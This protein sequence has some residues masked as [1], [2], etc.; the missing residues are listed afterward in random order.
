MTPPALKLR[1]RSTDRRQVDSDTELPQLAQG[2]LSDQSILLVVGGGRMLRRDDTARS[3]NRVLLDP[4]G[5][6]VGCRNA[7]QYW[8]GT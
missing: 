1:E 4:V 2:R 7:L 8:P 3:V 5:I 6:A